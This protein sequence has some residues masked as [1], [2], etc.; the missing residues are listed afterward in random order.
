MPLL[1]TAFNNRPLTRDPRASPHATDM[2]T[3][4]CFI[5]PQPRTGRPPAPPD[6]RWAAIGESWIY[7]K[8]GDDGSTGLLFGGRT[9][10]ADPL[11]DSYIE[12]IAED[13]DTARVD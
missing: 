4:E 12:A 6:R 9:S 2:H 13:P 11:I 10:K 1:D 5:D 7:T 8:L 3:E